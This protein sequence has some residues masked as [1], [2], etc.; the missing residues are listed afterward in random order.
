M[1]PH[2]SST[3]K[4]IFSL[5]SII[6]LFLVSSCQNRP[7]QTT[8]HKETSSV[9][10]LGKDTFGIINYSVVNMNSKGE[11]DADIVSQSLM[12]T[13]VRIRNLQSWLQIET[14]E[15]YKGWVTQA[16]VTRLD[17]EGMNTWTASPK[18]IF[19]K[20]CGNVYEQPNTKSQTISDL[21]SGNMLKLEGEQGIFYFVSFPDGRKGY[22]QKDE[23]QP[24]EQW[25]NNIQLTPESLIKR[26][27]SLLG[28]PYFWGGLSSKGV[29]CSGLIKYTTFMHGLILLRDASQQIKTGIRLNP[30]KDFENLKA[31]D[32]VFFGKAAE[33]DKKERVSHVG[34]YLGDKAF[35]HSM[36]SVHIS[37]FDPASPYYDEY[38]LGRFIGA[39]RFIES[40][41]TPGISTLKS[42]PFY[43][44][45]E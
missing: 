29:D 42:N 34:L 2:K 15:G 20:N 43:Q 25:L 35:I 45:Q 38:N 16:S 3:M 26:A 4:R 17:K 14:P 37:S 39:T 36:N 44:I 27:K 11:F 30:G 7:E 19:L 41:D 13:P 21:V 6:G 18:I 24:L 40:I 8:E 9:A 33:G 23:A 28:V 5:F 31:G 22:V 32:F 1:H 12:G 10:N